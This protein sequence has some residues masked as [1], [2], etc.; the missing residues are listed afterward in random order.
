MLTGQA[1]RARTAGGQ[2]VII[3]DDEPCIRALIGLVLKR[4][5][6]TVLEAQDGATALALAERQG[7]PIDLLLTDL[8]MPRMSGPALAERLKQL[9]PA[10]KVVYMSGNGIDPPPGPAP[11]R[12]VPILDKPFSPERL[13]A[14]VRR[15]LDAQSSADPRAFST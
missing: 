12:Q 13:I 8:R 11:D 1:Q 6:Y 9:C 7:G 10:L 14:T 3:A 4:Q 15:V 2:T 5:G